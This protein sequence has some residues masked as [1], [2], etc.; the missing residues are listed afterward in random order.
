MK[1]ERKKNLNGWQLQDTA[2]C[3]KK[4][5]SM[6]NGAEGHR[7][8]EQSNNRVRQQWPDSTTAS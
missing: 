2:V 4:K 3:K 6:D 8:V 5:N 7:C 1:E